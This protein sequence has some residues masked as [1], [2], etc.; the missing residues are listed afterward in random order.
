MGPEC[1]AAVVVRAGP[2]RW[3]GA[4]LT[5]LVARPRG[6]CL[7]RERRGGRFLG[8]PRGG[9][10]SV[11]RQAGFRV[12]VSTQQQCDPDAEGCEY[13]QGVV[14]SQSPEGGEQAEEDSAVT[15]VVNP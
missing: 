4:S 7:V 11:L 9:A 1:A 10:V 12:S 2:G 3:K 14:W 8:M 15:I 5:F 6:P 13:R